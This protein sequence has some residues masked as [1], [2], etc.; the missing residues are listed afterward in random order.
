MGIA[1]V[2]NLHRLYTWFDWITSRGTTTRHRSSNL[3][4]E[5]YVKLCKEHAYCGSNNLPERLLFKAF[6]LAKISPIVRKWKSNCPIE[7][8]P[9][10]KIT[11][12]LSNFRHRNFAVS[13][14]L[15]A[16]LHHLHYKHCVFRLDR[17]QNPAGATRAEKSDFARR[18]LKTSEQIESRQGQVSMNTNES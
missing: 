13:V 12:S 3:F 9:T 7:E 16:T 1:V 17:I 5:T 4:L 2:L 18:K 10:K 15:H 8:K 11:F 6:G 14:F